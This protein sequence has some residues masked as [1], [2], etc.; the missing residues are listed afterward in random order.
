MLRHIKEITIF[1]QV[2]F[3]EHEQKPEPHLEQSDDW[4]DELQDMLDDY[5]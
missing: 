5:D 1:L 4:D 2:K 3:D